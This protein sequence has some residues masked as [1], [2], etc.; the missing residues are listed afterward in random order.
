MIFA[1]IKGIFRVT[2]TAPKITTREPNKN[3]PFTNK[4]T[5]ALNRLVDLS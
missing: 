1:S 4:T 2:I 5:F 3:T